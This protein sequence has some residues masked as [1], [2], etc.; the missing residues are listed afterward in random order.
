ML[1]EYPSPEEGLSI[2]HLLFTLPQIARQKDV[3]FTKWSR[4]LLQAGLEYFGASEARLARISNDELYLVASVH[5]GVSGR[6]I[7]KRF[8]RLPP[9]IAVSQPESRRSFWLLTRRNILT[10]HH[11]RRG[12]LSLLL[13]GGFACILVAPYGEV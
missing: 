2:R 8:T 10:Y 6:F 1:P 3:E 5:E 7:M 12:A 13:I 4:H 11:M 9:H